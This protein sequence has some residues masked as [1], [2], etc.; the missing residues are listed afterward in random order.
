M[1][2]VLDPKG[3]EVPVGSGPPVAATELGVVVGLLP[4]D[5]TKELLI[6]VGS[7]FKVLLSNASRSDNIWNM[8]IVFDRPSI[9]FGRRKG[10]G[11]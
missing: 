5:K 10:G 7:G 3:V 8:Y 9:R 11:S 1:D 2:K 6:A 4:R